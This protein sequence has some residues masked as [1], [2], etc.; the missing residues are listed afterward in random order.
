MKKMWK[1][2]Y[3]YEN[4]ELA[5]HKASK[6]KKSKKEVMDFMLGFNKNLEHLADQI[7]NHKVPIGNYTYFRIKDPKERNICA[8]SF[9]ERVYH[10]ALMNIC[11]TGFEAAQIEHSYATRPQK[12]SHRAIA[13]C[14]KFSGQG[15]YWVKLDVKSFFDTI[16]HDT[17]HHLLEQYFLDYNI[18]KSFS[19][20]I[21]SYQA[22]PQRGLP[23]GNLTSQ[24]FANFYLS[25]LDRYA[26][27]I[28]GHNRY[29]R[30]MDD[31]VFWEHD[32]IKMAEVL[33]KIKKYL[34]NQLKQVFKPEVVNK[35]GANIPFLGF[36]ITPWDNIPNKRN[37]K[38]YA[39]KLMLLPTLHESEQLKNYWILKQFYEFRANIYN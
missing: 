10:H 38:K 2:V 3:S 17:L 19:Q 37:R 26:I 21:D 14:M 22:S 11:H 8:A 30:Y 18:V 13:Q 32:K 15:G 28:L 6:G 12:G 9:V 35:C 1:Q 20:I 23:I 31:I 36:L 29:I 5:F 33:E 34:E 16:H 39:K 4:I 7:K 25:F 24:Y 27:N